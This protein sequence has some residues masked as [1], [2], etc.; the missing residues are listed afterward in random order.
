GCRTC[1]GQRSS[2]P[3]AK[4]TRP[5]ADAEMTRPDMRGKAISCQFSLA[6]GWIIVPAQ[7]DEVSRS[8]RAKRLALREPERSAGIR[9]VV[10]A[11]WPSHE[12]VASARS[13]ESYGDG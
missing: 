7:R 12:P 5:G 9:L 11:L 4:S 2:V 1:R 6:R 13:R 8:N 10:E 3:P